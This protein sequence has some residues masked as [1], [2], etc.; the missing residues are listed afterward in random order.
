MKNSTMNHLPVIYGLAELILTSVLLSLLLILARIGVFAY[1]ACQNH[2]C[3]SMIPS[4]A[5]YLNG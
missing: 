1:V 5:L 3:D 4:F 2:V